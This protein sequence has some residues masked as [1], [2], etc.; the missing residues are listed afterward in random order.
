MGLI[1][2]P[3]PT[4]QV[5]STLNRDGTRLWLR[6]KVSKGVHYRRRFIVGWGLIATFILVP[7]LKLNGY[8][9]I[10]LNIPDREFHILGSTFLPTDT[11]VL[12]LLLFSI[13]V[14]I[15]LMT[16][17]LGRV[18][19]GWA[20]PQT[21]YMEFIYRPLEVWIEG[22]RSRQLKMDK[23]G[24]D[25]RRVL[26]FII[27]FFISAFLSN[28]FLAYFVGWQQLLEWMSQPPT[29][30]VGAFFLM[31]GTTALMTF[32]FAYFREQTCIVACPYGR[33]QSV[34]LD[35]HSLIVGYDP[36]RGEPRAPKR[37]G[38]DDQAGDC[39]DCNLCVTTCPTGIDIR[40]GLQ[41]ECIHCTQCIDACDA[42]MTKV[43]RE[44]GL[45]SYTSQE[46]LESGKRRFLR[47]RLFVYSAM[48]AL[49]FGGLVVSLAGK[50]SADVTLLRGLG[51]PFSQLPSGEISNQ[52]R[53]KIT[54][55][56]GEER[57]YHFGPSDTNLEFIAPENPM[58]LAD[59]ETQLT[60]AFITAPPSAFVEGEITIT[61]VI[62][63]GV[64]FHSERPYR[65]LGPDTG[66]TP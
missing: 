49:M 6:P 10:L 8:P 45:I 54:N 55:R 3:Q 12:M 11:F 51:A 36:E 35:R 25:G 20:C 56:S 64:D 17:V 61:I 43:G 32:D 53:L 63:D 59:G 19:C 1:N 44:K 38:S 21:V 41:M 26:K 14:G 7:I 33:F 66:G 31:F 18:W 37:K 58:T 42:V 30:H 57:Q 60:A 15:F 65:L 48:L 52:M 9:L 22:G 28:T 62:D 4:E 47:P 46:D 23:E 2:A 27:F 50:S 29:R 13:F 16:A 24:A 39:I 40:E 5:M 34:L